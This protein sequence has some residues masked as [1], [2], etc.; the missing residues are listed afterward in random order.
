MYEG[1][2]SR[3]IAF[4]VPAGQVHLQRGGSLINFPSTAF[5][6]K[7]IVENFVKGHISPEPSQRLKF[8]L[9]PPSAERIGGGI[10]PATTLK[11]P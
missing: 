2:G 3:Y 1:V 10:R 6:G 7:D 11:G 9:P 8:V 5:R 4:L